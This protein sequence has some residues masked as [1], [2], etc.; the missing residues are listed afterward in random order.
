MHIEYLREFE[1]LTKS[2]SFRDTAR[3]F[4][5]SPSVIS[6]HIASMEE[7]LGVQLFKRDKRGVA[8]TR[9]GEV[10]LESAQAITKE[11][12]AALNRLSNLDETGNPVIR[13][14]Y[15]HNAARP[16][17]MQFSA[18]INRYHPEIEIKYMGMTFRGLYSALDDGKVDLNFMLDVFPPTQRKYELTTMYRDE[19]CVVVK[20][21]SE[22]TQF[23]EGVRLDQLVGRKLMI[24][25]S[26]QYPGLSE[27]VKTIFAH[28]PRLDLTKAT[29]YGDVD[30][31]YIEIEM[32]DKLAISTSANAPFSSNRV[33]Y[34]PIIGVDAGINV[35]AYL[36][37]SLS[38]HTLNCCKEAISSC[39][40]YL[41]DFT[42]RKN[43]EARRG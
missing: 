36:G 37:K 30:S 2:L 26:V 5:A 1:Y 8:I 33:A 21:D 29:P 6:R 12:N 11:Y 31:M 40:P 14:G 32:G 9:A 15:L 34:L 7:Q 16:F 22:L 27:R 42:I 25:D 24:P 13:L 35:N 43:I 28:E 18:Y 4:F 19:F 38:G 3:H 41:K 20:S 39:I 10:F 17:I 23:K